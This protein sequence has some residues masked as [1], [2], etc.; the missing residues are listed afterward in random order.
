MVQKSNRRKTAGTIGMVAAT[1]EQYTRTRENV[2]TGSAGGSFMRLNM[3]AF[4]R[5]S[6][7]FR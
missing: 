4:I 2:I 7:R 6:L 3:N 1:A 5:S